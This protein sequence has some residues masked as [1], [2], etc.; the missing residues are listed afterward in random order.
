MPLKLFNTLDIIEFFGLIKW[1]IINIAV[2][3]VIVILTGFINFLRFILLP[4]CLILYFY[5]YL[6]QEFLLVSI[7]M[8]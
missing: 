1:S 3:P 7:N 6:M 5:P 8:G 2:I 4:H